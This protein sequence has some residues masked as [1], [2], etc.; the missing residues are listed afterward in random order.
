M[1]DKDPKEVLKETLE[2][3]E[4]LKDSFNSLG[5]IIKNTIKDNLFEVDAITKSIGKNIS[6]DISRGFNSLGKQSE[7]LLKNQDLLSKGQAKSKDIQK[8]ITD[9]KLKELRLQGDINTA[10]A[11]QV[12]NSTTHNDKIN[13]LNQKIQETNKELAKQLDRAQKI[14]NAMGN[15]GKLVTGLNKIPILG[16]FIKTED[17]LEAMQQ[18]A[19]DTNSK[20]QTML[21]GIKAIGINIKDA[22]LDPLT[23]ISFFLKAAIT[24]NKESVNLSKNLGYG[25]ANA[26]R[27]RANFVDIESSSNNLNVNTAN[28]AEAFNELSTSTGFVTEYSADALETQIKLTKQLGLSGNEAAGVYKFSVLTGKSSEQ[29]YQSL[30]RGYVATRNSLNV[31]VP[32][33]AAIA[34]AAKVSGQLASNLGNNPE[35]IIKAVVATRALGTSLEQAKSQGEK[36]LDFQSSIENE[37]KAELITGQQLNLERARAAALMGDQVTVAEE[38]A[39]QGMTAAK[40]SQMNVIAQQSYAAALGTT[41]DELADQLAKRELAIASGKSLA[42]ITAEEAEEAAERQD[43]QEKF[44]AAM[45]KLQ[46]IVGNLL[47]GPLG[48]FLEMLAKGL[49]IINKMVPVLTTIGAL[50]VGFNVAKQVGLGFDRA[51]F[52]L[53]GQ[54]MG[55]Q[56]MKNGLT[57]FENRQKEVGRLMDKQGLI[58]RIAYNVQLGSS[59]AIE[60]TISGAKKLQIGIETVL[61]SLKRSGLAVTIMEARKS[62]ASAAMAAYESAAKI[63]GIGWILGGIAAAGVVALGASLMTK[64]DDVVSEGGYGKRTLLS[65]EG[66]IQLNDKDTV[67]A[68]TNLGGGETESVKSTSGIDLSPMISAINQVTTAVNALNAKKWDVY[69]DSKVVGT[70][71]MQKS[72][73]SA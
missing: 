15:L 65:P 46:S 61:L 2:T 23:V 8:Q 18:K 19:S 13:E 12:I 62:I 35:T 31:G 47:A 11:N 71:L 29:T 72:Y 73:K 43:I 3:V 67:I 44:N 21:A 5:A 30:L 42:Q 16:Q 28:L 20:F 26:D 40:F 1:A 4:I 68:G 69:L 14:E 22:L 39:A 10:L 34:E 49:D 66:A 24:A 48:S 55:Q 59:A 37:L 64:G 9:L 33:K 54:E 53:K 63:P 57:V 50:Y 38:L 70:G 60:G 25:A 17:V 27:V 45:L 36:L 51:A 32:F 41:S 52:V 7:E 6:N 56:V 58:S